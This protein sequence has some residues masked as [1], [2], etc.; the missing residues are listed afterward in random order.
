[1][2][3]L[4]E[5]EVEMLHQAY[6]TTK[7]ILN[8]IIHLEA[9]GMSEINYDDPRFWGLRGRADN[10]AAIMYNIYYGVYRPDKVLQ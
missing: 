10:L 6:E 5:Y 7:E 3:R 8:E 1:M 4:N 9:T 2:K